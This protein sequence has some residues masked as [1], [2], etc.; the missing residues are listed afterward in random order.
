MNAQPG[1]CSVAST[2]P[3]AATNRTSTPGSPSGVWI[4]GGPA[5]G[6]RLLGVTP[7]PCSTSTAP[8]S[9]ARSPSSGETV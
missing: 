5:T 8:A 2:V 3:S 4:H 7:M 1:R 6:M 9:A